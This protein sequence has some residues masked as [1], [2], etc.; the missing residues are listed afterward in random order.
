[1]LTEAAEAARSEAERLQREVAELGA[2][3]EAM[4]RDMARQSAELAQVSTEP[5]G[6]GWYGGRKT[7]GEDEASN[8]CRVHEDEQPKKAQETLGDLGWTSCLR[9]QASR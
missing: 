9:S 5:A 8:R 6:S 2:V 7:V 1:M 4:E 3:R